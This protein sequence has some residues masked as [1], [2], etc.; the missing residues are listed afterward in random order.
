MARDSGLPV[1][2]GCS[3][4]DDDDDTGP[5]R[6]ESMKLSTIAREYRGRDLDLACLV[7]GGGR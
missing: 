7:V 2:L 1:Y 5:G 3:I 6:E 4:C